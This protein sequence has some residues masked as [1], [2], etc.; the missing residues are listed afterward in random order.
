MEFSSLGF[1]KGYARKQFSEEGERAHIAWGFGEVEIVESSPMLDMS[2]KYI[3]SS[4]KT[5]KRFL[6]KRTAKTA[7]G[8]VSSQMMASF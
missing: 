8:K 1:G 7:E 5:A 6:F 4:R 2:Y 3:D